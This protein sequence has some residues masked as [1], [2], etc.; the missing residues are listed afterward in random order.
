MQSQEFQQWV[1]SSGNSSSPSK[2]GT[3]GKLP[4]TAR[5]M[6]DWVAEQRHRKATGRSYDTTYDDYVAFLASKK[7]AKTPPPPT[8]GA[9]GSMASA[10]APAANG[11]N[12]AATSP[13]AGPGAVKNGTM[14]SPSSN[15]GI[16][17]TMTSSTSA[18]TKN[19]KTTAPVAATK[20]VNPTKTMA[21]ANANHTRLPLAQDQPI[22][23]QLRTLHQALLAADADYDGHCVQ[24]MHHLHKATRHL[25]GADTLEGDYRFGGTMT[26]TQEESDQLLNNTAAKLKRVEAELASRPGNAA[27]HTQARAEVA[28]AIREIHTALKIR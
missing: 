22:I 2:A 21:V 20:P 10:S 3:D 4:E 12:P 18:A 16:N 6:N 1:K 28:H 8:T 11:K 5:A 9:N 23:G 26:M 24:A 15:P 17:G 25:S 14:T 7:P 27:H 13:S 19:G